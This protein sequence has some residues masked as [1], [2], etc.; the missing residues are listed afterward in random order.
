MLPSVTCRVAVLVFVVALC[1]PA[2]ADARLSTRYYHGSTELG[3]EVAL[4]A[5]P[6]DRYVVLSVGWRVRCR[7]FR[8][9]DVTSLKPLRYATSGREFAVVG[10]MG[11]EDADEVT[12]LEGR[13]ASIELSMTG[14]RVTPRG[15]PGGETWAGI[16]QIEVELRTD[17]DRSKVVGR[18]Q[19]RQL[20]WRAWREGYG[21]GSLRVTG[22]PG[23]YVSEGRAWSYRLS[24]SEILATGDRQSVAFIA[25]PGDSTWWATFAAGDGQTL[26]RGAHFVAGG[27]DGDPR[28]EVERDD[29]TC[30]EE[31]GEF[32]V[33]SIRLRRGRIHDITVT[34]EQ[35]CAG[36]PASL[37]GTLTFRSSA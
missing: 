26:R 35:R 5:Q 6:S 31:V 18:C 7:G 1:V 21:T 24:S 34:F 12:P 19:T 32:T 16:L 13:T 4:Q 9:E 8:A 3:G 30:S 36:A 33:Q 27:N 11:G 28:M 2:G 25:A 22:A 20:R 29:R 23:E 37:S 15:R 17:D 14:R 10:T